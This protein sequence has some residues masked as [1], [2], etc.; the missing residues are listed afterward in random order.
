M[1]SENG[2]LKIV[3]YLIEKGADLN[4]KDYFGKTAL[5]LA[6]DENFLYYLSA[7]AQKQKIEIAKF[8]TSI[9]K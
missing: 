7:K 3:Q 2:H 8:L 6:S 4:A 9:T 5:K 1:A